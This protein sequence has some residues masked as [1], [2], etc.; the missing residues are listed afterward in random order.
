MPFPHYSLRQLLIAVTLFI[1]VVLLGRFVVWPLIYPFTPGYWDRMG[2][3]YAMWQTEEMLSIHLAR[4]DGALPT[5]W[6]DLTKEFDF[7]NQTYNFPGI[8]SLQERV[9]LD[10]EALSNTVLNPPEEGQLPDPPV[11]RFQR[12]IGKARL[13]GFEVEVNERLAP[14][15]EAFSAGGREPLTPGLDR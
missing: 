14:T 3:V 6:E 8:E 2:D 12:G 1:G 4:S 5:R 7:T 11:L 13:S 9:F 15:L 10:F